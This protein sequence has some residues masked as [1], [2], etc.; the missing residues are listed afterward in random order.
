MPYLTF[1]A[2]GLMAATAMQTSAGEGAFPVMAGIKWRKEFHGAITTPLSPTDIVRGKMI[3]GSIR[4]TFVLTVFA[5]ISV[6]FGA[7]DLVPGP[8]RRP[9]GGTHRAGI[10]GHGHRVHGDP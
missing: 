5:L 3:W 4:L 8:P 1:V 10:P 6:A 9:T 7:L 2:T